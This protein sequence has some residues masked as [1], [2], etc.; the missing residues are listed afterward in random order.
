MLEHDK[1]NSAITALV[2]LTLVMRILNHTNRLSFMLHTYKKF[3][4]IFVL[5]D[6]V[7]T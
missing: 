3:D 6:S 2:V 7:M 5:L 4:K 1:I